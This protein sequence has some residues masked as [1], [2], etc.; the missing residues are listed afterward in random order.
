MGKVTEVLK[1]GDTATAQ[2]LTRHRFFNTSGKPVVFLCELIPASGGFENVLRIGCGLARDGKAAKNGMPKNI[3][4]MA[5]LMNMGEGYFVG[6]FSILEKFF[7]MLANTKKAKRTEK[8]L[9]EKYC[10]QNINPK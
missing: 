10:K 4:H 3:I 1:P 8:I 6:T 5:I 2:I 7:R 9:L